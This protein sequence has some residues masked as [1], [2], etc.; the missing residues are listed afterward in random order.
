MN[1]TACGVIRSCLSQDLKH[2]VM[3]E[4]FA[5]KIWETLTSKYFTK[6]VKNGLYLKR[7]LYHFQLKR[8]VSI[9]DHINIYTKLLTDLENVDV[10]IDE[11][12]KALIFL[13]SLP[14]ERYETF[15]LTLIKGR[16]SLSYSE[17]TTVLVNFELKRKDKKSLSGISTE[18]LTVRGRSLNQ[19]GEN[20]CRSKS[21]SRYSNCSLTRDQYAFCKQTGHR[22]K[23][24]PKLKKKIRAKKKSVKPSEVNVTRSDGNDS[25]YSGFSFYYTVSMLLRCFRMVIR[26]RATYHI[27]P[28]RNDFL[29]SRS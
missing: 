3:N 29:A 6:S 9:S 22:K 15:V 1:R 13:S 14:D 27:C 26:Y 20:H 28:R 19:R 18:V 21:G 16:T 7:R 12:D 17:V 25:D 5:K 11:E 10:V 4:T 2:D 23:D 24:C 8:G